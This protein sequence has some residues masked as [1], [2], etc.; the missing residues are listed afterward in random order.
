VDLINEGIKTTLHNSSYRI[1]FYREYMETVLFS[2]P[3][4]QQLI[5]EFY[6]HKYQNHMPDVIITV[7]PSPLG[8]MIEKHKTAF[9]GVPVI[10]CLPNRLPGGFN[11]D[12]D[13]TG[14]DGDTAPAA[15][16]EAALRL[17]PG[18]KRVVVVGGT[19]SFDRQQSAAVREQLKP[20]EKGLDISYLADLAMPELLER[21]APV[22]KS[23]NYL[24]H[25]SGEGC[26]GDPVHFER[27]GS[28]DYFCCECSRLHTVRQ[29]PESWRGRREDRKRSRTRQ[30]RR[31]YGSS[32]PEW[33]KTAKH[34]ESRKRNRLHVR[35]ARSEAL[36]PKGK[37]SSPR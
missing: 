30:D 5:R 33:R 12:S 37:Q 27:I 13:F 16:L 32:S 22:A 2:S 15:T 18:T 7:G 24:A 23:H 28:N 4:D 17:V 20:Y 36:G 29:G 1:E 10:F 8:F 19:S 35:L 21:L 11:A 26:G 6:V 3:A 34:S 14:V 9:P 31:C 25:R